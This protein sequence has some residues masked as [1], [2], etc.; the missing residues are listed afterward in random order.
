MFH[1]KAVQKINTHISMFNN[2]FK[3]CAV[4]EIM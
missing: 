2:Y 3:N 4:N 1:T